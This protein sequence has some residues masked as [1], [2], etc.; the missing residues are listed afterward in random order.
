MNKG[1]TKKHSILEALTQTAI[2]FSVGLASQLIFFP[3]F[4]ID[5]SLHQNLQISAIFTV[6][7]IARGYILRRGF[8][9]WMVKQINKLD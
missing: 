8:N 6:I 5:I 3:M 7:S 4:D 2:G 9:A 1:Q